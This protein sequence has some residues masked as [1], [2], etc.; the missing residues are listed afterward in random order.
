MVYSWKEDSRAPG[1]PNVFG[2]AVEGLSKDGQVTTQAIVDAARPADSPLHAMFLWNDK[3]AAETYRRQQA[4]LYIRCLCVVGELGTG[5][6]CH[7]SHVKIGHKEEGN[8]CYVTLKKAMSSEEMR[9]QVLNDT[10]MLLEGI[11][12]R[13]ANLVELSKVFAAIKEARAA[14]NRK[15]KKDKSAAG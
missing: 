3:E 9:A 4:G 7:L 11:Q 12:K 15:R 6:V 1:D 13:Y 8:N 10:L 14:L 2:R 5:K